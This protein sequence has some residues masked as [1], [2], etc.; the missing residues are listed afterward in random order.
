M[1]ARGIMVVIAPLPDWTAR[2]LLRV[3]LTWLGSMNFC[4]GSEPVMLVSFLL[5]SAA[6]NRAGNRWNQVQGH[7]CPPETLA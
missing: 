4:C 7:S 5:C 3:I 6:G 2:P 1:A